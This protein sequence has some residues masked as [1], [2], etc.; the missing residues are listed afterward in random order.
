VERRAAQLDRRQQTVRS[1]AHGALQPRRARNRRPGDDQR[2]VLDWHDEGLF[3]VAMAIVLMSCVDAFF[4]LNLLNLGAQ[5]INY[6][7]QV[8][9]ATDTTAFLLTKFTLTSV[10][11][12]CLVAFAPFRLGGLLRVRRILEALC[13]MYACLII[14]ELYLLTAVAVS[15]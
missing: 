7:M 12:I 13:G 5:E 10:G 3:T 4:T 9:L 15:S 2:F 8:L 14:W 11:V 1:V 6:F